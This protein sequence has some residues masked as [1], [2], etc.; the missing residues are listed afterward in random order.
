MLTLLRAQQPNAEPRV[1]PN[2]PC[3]A[4]N[5]QGSRLLRSK[6]LRSK[7][8]GGGGGFALCCLQLLAALALCRLPRRLRVRRGRRV[9]LGGH[10][11]VC[12]GVEPRC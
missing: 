9:I 1:K 7:R 12:V 10:S 4:G 8:S 6:P 2:K 5:A 3:A 11:G